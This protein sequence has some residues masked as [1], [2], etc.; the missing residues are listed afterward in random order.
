[1]QVRDGPAAVRG[2]ALRHDATGPRLGKAAEGEP[3]V[4]RP[5]GRP[6]YRSPRGRRNRGQARH[7][8]RRVLRSS[9]PRLRSRRPS[10]SAS[11]GKT[12][13][14]FAPTEVTVTASNALDALE[15]ASISGELYYHVTVTGL[16]RVRR[17]GR[18]LRRLRLERLGVQGRRRLAAGR[19]RPG[20][21]E[22]RRPRALVLREFGPNGGPPT[23]ELN[24]AAGGCYVAQALRRQRQGRLRSSDLVLH[25]G[26][27]RTMAAQTGRRS[28]RGRTR[29]CSCARPPTARCDRTRVK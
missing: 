6:P 20:G 23:L 22:G 14:L 11:K 9:C 18:P 27:S 15:Q 10:R 16:R 13:T 25:I 26:S 12:Q 29:A 7:S 3:R 1:M 24:A 17:P 19:R 21:A 8:A 4:R 2:D 5:A 28:A